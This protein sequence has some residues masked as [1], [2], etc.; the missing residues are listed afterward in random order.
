MYNKTM[1]EWIGHIIGKVR[2]EKFLAR[3]GMAEVYLGRHLTL[4]RPV[5]VKVMHSHIEADP[6]LLSRFQR[7]AKV[8]ASLRHPNIVQV[9]DLDT[10]EGHPYIVMEYI[11]GQSLSSYQKYLHECEQKLSYEQVSR[12]LG[13]IAAG[14]D[15]AHSQMVIHRDIKPGNILLHSRSREFTKNTPI[16]RS[17]E[18]IITD[19]GL[20]RIAHAKTQTAS[21][22][23]SGTPTYMSPE[24]ARGDQVDHHTDIY[25][26]GIIL[27]EM[28]AGHVPFEGD[29]A[30]AIIYQHIHQPPPPIEGLPLQIQAVINRALAKKP[31]DR[32]QTAGQM[33]A[34]FNEAI[35]IHAK[36]KTIPPHQYRARES[37]TAPKI[38]TPFWIGAAIFACACVS[39]LLLGGLGISAMNL[40]P[41]RE[42]AQT[43][44]TSTEETIQPSTEEASK[45]IVPNTGSSPAGI[46]R[47][48]NSIATMDQIT[49]NA[50]LAPLPENMQYEAWMVDDEREQSRSL[51]VLKQGPDGQFSLTFVESQSQNLIAL[52]NRIEITLEPS[53]DD[54]P[55]SSRNILYSASL[56]PGSLEHIRHL[57]VGTEETPGQGAVAVGLVNN[58]ALIQQSA[59][60][61]LEAF[62]AE[63]NSGV[64][65][66]AEA[67]VN[68]IVGKEDLDFYKDWDEDGS[69]NDPGDGYGLLINGS[70]AGYLDGMIHHTSYSADAPEA[71][72]DIQLHATHVEIC[73]QNLEAWA[74]EL[75]DLTVNI[76]RA[77]EA[78]DVEAD[79]RE[80]VALANQMLDGIDIDGSETV[81]PIPG[82]GGA[83]TAFAHVGYMADMPIFPSEGQTI[84][85]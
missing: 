48:Q 23:I 62:N 64:R 37:A 29:S 28:L 43:I 54:S 59:E 79:L 53:P 1:P 75:R 25:S 66:N 6:D 38:Q 35:G 5:A 82:E 58:V 57:T 69:I 81:D 65:S 80:A 3:G 34:A 42:I 61:M 52:F 30:I 24:Q 33:S 14:L 4:D 49:I 74:P 39:F 47:F 10:H 63:D 22:L 17:V 19:F 46:L 76:A 45:V 26:L 2:I 71:T 68:L 15:H 16:T 32:F 11:R 70:Q 18:P 85:P 31:D 84:T 51:G 20:V 41:K 83:L 78:Q 9:M 44:P 7:E 36:A 67:I 12:I 73:T 8:V 21:G 40:L 55:N 56:P 77:P 27:Y 72:S 13:G 50:T 60:A